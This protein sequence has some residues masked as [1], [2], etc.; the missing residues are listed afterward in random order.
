MADMAACIFDYAAGGRTSD[1]WRGTLSAVWLWS[2]LYSPTRTFSWLEDIPIIG[3]CPKGLFLQM[4]GLAGI[5]L[6][7][8]DMRAAARWWLHTYRCAR[9]QLAVVDY[10]KKFLA[11]AQRYAQYEQEAVASGAAHHR[12]LEVL[13]ERAA[14]QA[15]APGD[16]ALAAVEDSPMEDVA[17]GPSVS[18]SLPVSSPLPASA[19]AARAE[20][21]RSMEQQAAAFR[22]AFGAE[23]D[24]L[25]LDEETEEMEGDV[26]VPKG[27]VLPRPG[28]G[29]V[30][31]RGRKAK[32]LAT[33]NIAGVYAGKQ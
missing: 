16:G 27:T 10:G 31:H 12:A 26:V 11:R 24:A 5:T 21:L 22:E 20:A 32:Q 25:E 15:A 30:P 2:T 28:G 6:T 23:L 19:S 18:V 29:V 14:V 9:R 17:A 33:V 3:D 4:M 7:S 8:T 1:H 13:A